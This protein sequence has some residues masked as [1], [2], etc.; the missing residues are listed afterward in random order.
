MYVTC[1][2]SLVGFTILYLFLIF[3]NLIAMCLCVFF[4]VFIL[5]GTLCFSHFVDDF[6]AHVQQVFN[7]HLFK[8]FLSSF[9]LLFSFWDPYN[10]NVGTF[11][12]FP[13]V[14]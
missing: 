4:L 14:S 9:L 6:L 1:Y 8:Y 7:H 10:A 11:D 3:V 13:E 2:F 5:P 12:V